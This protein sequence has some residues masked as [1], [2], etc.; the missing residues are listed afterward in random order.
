MGNFAV[1]TTDISVS[2]GDA[3]EIFGKNNTVIKMAGKLNTIPYEIYAT[4]NRRI[5]RIYID[6]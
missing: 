3:V 2:E 5:K 6:N 1:D 4:L